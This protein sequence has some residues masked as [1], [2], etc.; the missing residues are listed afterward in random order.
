MNRIYRVNSRPTR[1]KNPPNPANPCSFHTD[2]KGERRWRLFSTCLVLFLALG[3]S[4]TPPPPTPT[5]PPSPVPLPTA[6]PWP[7]LA[8]PPTPLP[9]ATPEPVDSGWLP[10]RPGAEFRLI[11]VHVESRD[12]N[13]RGDL[14]E[15]VHIVRVDPATARFRVLYE[16]GRP[17]PVDQWYKRLNP[18]PMLVVNGG[19]FTP[20]DETVGVLVSDGETW[21]VPYG[22]FAG[23]FAVDV[24]G[25]VSIRWFQDWPYNAAEPLAQA[26]QSFPVLVKPGGVMGFPADADDGRPA[27]RTVTALDRQGR[28]LFIAAP[29]GYLSLHALARFL[30]ESDLALD[31]A[32][33]LD[34]G[35]STGMWLRTDER[36]VTINSY[37][38]VPSVLAVFPR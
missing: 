36:T 25:G 12:E 19:Y 26:I 30:A 1:D 20:E 35:Y 33:N 14:V 5:P 38:P 32:L 8:P 17:M 10:L 3:C 23:M 27:R 7:T 37:V 4:L 21:G 6:T 16:P 31:V 29:R 11:R 15:R 28:V 18:P 13:E 9:S 34:G 24:N 22:D 2:V